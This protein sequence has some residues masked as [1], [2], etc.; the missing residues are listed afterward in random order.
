M[1]ELHTAILDI[2]SKHLDANT[3]D[4]LRKHIDANTS[5]A[6]ADEILQFEY[7]DLKTFEFEVFNTVADYIAYTP[8][9]EVAARVALAFK[10]IAV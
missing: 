8:A 2:L 10:E 1:K 3:S 4:L 6:L 5:E 7:T 9:R